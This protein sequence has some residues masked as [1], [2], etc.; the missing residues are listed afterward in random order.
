MGERRPHVVILGGGFGGLAAARRLKRAPVRVTLVDKRNHHLFQPLLYQVATAAL[1]APDIAAPLRKVLRKQ[2]N[3]TVLMGRVLDIDVEH[4]RVTLDHGQL[5]YDYLIV[6][7]GMTHNYFGHPEWEQHAPGLKSLPEALDIRARMLRAYEAAERE[8]D[9]A[10]RK[11]LLTFVVIGGGP[12]GVEMAGALAEIASRTLASDFRNFEPAKETRVILLEGAPR[13]LLAF[14]EESSASAKLAL[15]QLGV[16]VRTGAMVRDV[17]AHGVVY[18]DGERIDASTVIWAAGL[19]AS[20]LTADLGGELDRAG[21]VKV[22]PDLTVPGHPEVYVVGDLVHLEQDGKLLPGV[23]QMALQ[24]GRFAAEQI[25]REVRGE[26]KRERFVYRDKGSMA[27]I[28]RAK[29]V[30][31]VGRAKFDGL[32]AFLLWL[33]VHIFFLIDFRNRVSVLLEWAYAYFTWRR[34]ARVILDAPTRRRPA[35]QRRTIIAQALE[36]QRTDGRK[37]RAASPPP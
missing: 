18:G 6:A 5:E 26:P 24:S 7:T 13:L 35:A 12:T 2:K 10:K 9:P 19:K 30:A 20:P 4:R 25:E 15:E 32:L 11:E 23:A 1:T 8:P 36:A 21:R 29:A 27:T 14:S 28:G 37:Q 31:E 16:D 3:T 34:S 22:R 33:V 17:D